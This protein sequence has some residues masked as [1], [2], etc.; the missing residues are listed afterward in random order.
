MEAAL[1]DDLERIRSHVS[2]TSQAAEEE[3]KG[4]EIKI[5]VTWDATPYNITVNSGR[6]IYAAVRS[7]FEVGGSPILILSGGE[8]IEEEENLTFEDLGALSIH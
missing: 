5:H 7:I 1:V 6:P 4:E 2:S 3:G 8:P